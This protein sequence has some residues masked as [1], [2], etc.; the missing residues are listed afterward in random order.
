MSCGASSAAAFSPASSRSY[1]ISTRRVPCF[2][3]ASKWSSVKPFT[4]Q[5]V[6]HVPETGA[7]EGQRVDQR[8]AE[9]HV[10]SRRQRLDVPDAAVRPGQV[11]MRRRAVPDESRCFRPYIDEDLAVS[12]DERG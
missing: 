11:E 5:E 9:D 8:L 12:D 2:L 1:A 10:F 7:P 6:G 4:P 3:K